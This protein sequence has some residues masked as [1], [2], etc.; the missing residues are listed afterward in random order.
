[1]GLDKV[2][3]VV[4]NAVAWTM[5]GLAVAFRIFLLVGLLYGVYLVVAVVVF[6]F[7]ESWWMGCYAVLIVV[8][9]A[10]YFRHLD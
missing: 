2:I 4:A 10:W 3:D 9:M 1:M 8:G 7:L 6:A 5:L